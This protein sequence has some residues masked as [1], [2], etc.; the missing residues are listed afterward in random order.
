MRGN[1]ARFRKK[2][3]FVLLQG[4]GGPLYGKQRH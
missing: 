4:G 1:K 3:G 2:A